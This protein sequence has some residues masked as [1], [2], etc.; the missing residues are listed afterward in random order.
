MEIDGPIFVSKSG[1]FLLLLVKVCLNKLAFP[2]SS[3]NFYS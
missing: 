3:H 1:Y 2:P